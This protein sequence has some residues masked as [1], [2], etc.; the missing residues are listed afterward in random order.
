MRCPSCGHSESKVVDSRPG[1]EGGAI[2]R[3]R[4]CESCD[5]RF[6]T[7]ERVDADLVVQKRDGRREAFA[8]DKLLRSLT[9]ACRKRP[10]PAEDLQR[11]VQGVE[12]RLL[13]RGEVPSSVIGEAVLRELARIDQ[14][15]WVR[16]ASVYLRFEGIEEFE[17][18]ADEARRLAAVQEPPGIEP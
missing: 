2:R 8:A 7:W 11:V 9:L 13:G 10:V 1:P 12:A 3:R 14:V 4:A 5:F 16:F 15:A 17:R 18:F 6:T